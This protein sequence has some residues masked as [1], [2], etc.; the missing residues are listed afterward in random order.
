V[1]KAGSKP[2]IGDLIA[3]GAVLFLAAAVFMLFLPSPAQGGAQVEIYKDGKLHSSYPL[4]AD[5]S[6]DID[7]EYHNTVVIEGG[8]VCVAQS[9]CPGADCVH[10]GSISDVGRSIVCLPNRVEI[11]ISGAASNDGVDIVVG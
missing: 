10:S 8:R 2:C 1:R 4:D 7:G 11:R 3:V 6:I 9:D 5:R